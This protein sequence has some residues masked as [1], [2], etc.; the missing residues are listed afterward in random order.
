MTF[1]SVLARTTLAVRPS[2]SRLLLGLLAFLTFSPARSHA[3]SKAE[4]PADADQAKAVQYAALDHQRCIEALEQ[5]KI[6]FSIEK[7]AP[8][9]LIPVRLLGPLHGVTWRTDFNG[10]QRR[11]TP[12]EVIDCRLLLAI[13]DLSVILEQHDVEEVRVFSFWRPPAKDWPKDKIAKR[14]PG[15]LAADVRLFKKRPPKSEEK[16]PEGASDEGKQ[17][18]KRS[19]PKKKSPRKRTGPKKASAENE[20]SVLEDFGGKIG[21]KACG[22]RAT[23]PK[24][25]TAKARELREIFCEAAAQRLFNVMLTPHFDKHHFNHFHLEV[26]A[27]VKWFIVD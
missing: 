18:A 27:G 25:D 3:E 8:G 15:G 21:G 26:T 4:F 14:H 11:T 2:G 12:Y 20:L 13:D 16:A 9:V 19:S 22:K 6:N 5:R 7:A 24:P 17:Q 1:R 23:P 10:E